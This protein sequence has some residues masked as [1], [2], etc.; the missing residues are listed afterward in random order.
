M[1]EPQNLIQKLEQ[2]HGPRESWPVQVREMRVEYMT[3]F[4]VIQAAQRLKESL[5]L[6]YRQI[7]EDIAYLTQNG[8]K[9]PKQSVMRAMRHDSKAGPRIAMLILIHYRNAKTHFDESGMPQKYM[10][11]EM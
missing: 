3:A 5:G 8:K 11:L 10:R 6:S 9:I 1:S 7:G 2:D 4:E